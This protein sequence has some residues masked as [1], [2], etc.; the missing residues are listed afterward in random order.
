MLVILLS[1]L[2]TIVG[3]DSVV[4]IVTVYELNSPGIQSRWGEIFLTFN[5][6]VGLNGRLQGELCFTFT[7]HCH[8]MSLYCGQQTF[9]VLKLSRLQ[10]SIKS[11][12][13][14]SRF[15]V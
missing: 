4:I 12:A 14:D 15:K 9:F 10:N 3:W 7:P 2:P 13:A 8:R 11:S 1:L 6:P 5:P